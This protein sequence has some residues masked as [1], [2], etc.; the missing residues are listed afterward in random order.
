MKKNIGKSSGQVFTPDFIVDNILDYCG[1]KGSVI[2]HKHIIDNSCG[3]GAFLCEIVKRYCESCIGIG[4]SNG[5]IQYDLAYYIHGVD[6]DSEAVAACIK[7]LNSIAERYGIYDVKWDIRNENAL[8]ITD[9]YGKMDFVVGNPPYVRVHNLDDSYED[10][11]QFSFSSGGMTDLYLSFYELGF[12]MLAANGKLCYITPSSWL[13]SVAAF[14]MRKY[15]VM[16]KNLVS[17]IDLG[18]FQPFD[19]VSTYTLIALFSNNNDTEEFGYYV[20]DENKKDRTFVCNLSYL[21]IYIDGCFYLSDR[22]TL[23]VLY[24]IKSLPTAQFVK[25]KNGFATLADDVFI[26]DVIPDSPYTITAFKASTGKSYKCFFPYDKN[27][28]PI[29]KDI[30]FSDKNIEKYMES[31]KGDILRGKKEFPEW[32][33]YGRTQ[34]LSDVNKRKIAVN[35]II[36]NADSLKIHEIPAGCGIYGGLYILTEESIDTIKKILV[37]QEFIEYIS[38]LKKYKSGGYY[39]FGSKDM[40]QYINYKLTYKDECRKHIA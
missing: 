35:T 16:R 6:S 20:Y 5:D 24:N 27:G 9:Y 4:I 7:S 26:N 31:R 38:L 13:N 12:R 37:N 28:K 10:V 25:V 1:Y 34:A 30:L 3:N 17:L 22:K 40:E 21:D 39:T 33:L 15:I 32:Y 2:V 29:G 19:N 11:K 18:H 36:K 14:C 8:K 23:N